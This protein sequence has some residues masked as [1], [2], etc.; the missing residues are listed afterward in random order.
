M[1]LFF[2]ILDRLNM[3]V[4]AVSEMAVPGL[5]SLD[6]VLT[7]SRGMV[8]EACSVLAGRGNGCC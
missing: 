6:D 7:G 5:A 2:G 1:F 8:G 3:E 4:C